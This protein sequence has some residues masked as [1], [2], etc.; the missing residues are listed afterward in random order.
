[1]KKRTITNNTLLFND[2]A[3]TSLVKRDKTYQ[4]TNEGPGIA[5]SLGFSPEMVR[6]EN[7]TSYHPISLFAFAGG[8]VIN[9]DNIKD[10]AKRSLCYDL[11]P[12]LLERV[13]ITFTYRAIFNLRD[14]TNPLEYYMIPANATLNYTDEFTNSISAR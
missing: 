7:I 1:M 11:A 9:Y 2:S 8:Q 12:K 14:K 13:R 3:I 6:A 10:V 5:I 4:L